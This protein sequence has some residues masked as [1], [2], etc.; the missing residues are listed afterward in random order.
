MVANSRSQ[1]VG[2]IDGFVKILAC[3]KTDRVLGAHIIGC[4]AGSLIHEIAVLMEFNGSSQDLVL[5]C[6]GHP[7]FNEAIKDAALTCN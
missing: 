1:A 3:K 7:T 4:E 2:Q 6:H 5:T